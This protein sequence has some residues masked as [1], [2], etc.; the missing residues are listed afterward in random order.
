MRVEEVMTRRVE[1]ASPE[2]PL[3]DVA[4][5]L[6]QHGIGAMPIIDERGR[7]LGLVSQTDIL[8]HELAKTPS[9][10]PWSRAKKNGPSSTGRAH[11]AAEAMNVSTTTINPNAT[12]ETATERMLADGLNHLPVVTGENLVGIVTPHDLIGAITRNDNELEQQIRQEAMATLNW[13][14]AL[15]LAVRDGKVALRGQVD[16]VR[17]ARS[18]PVQV[19]RILGVVSVDAGAQGLGSKRRANHRRNDAHL[20]NDWRQQL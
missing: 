4:T 19:R 15:E 5:R 13:P 2:T 14:Q 18:R 3:K 9:R 10:R 6:W 17:D 1:T 20:T 11:T 8:S 16:S 7:L 12:L